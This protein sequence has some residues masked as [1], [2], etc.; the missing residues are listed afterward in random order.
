MDG[1]RF[2]DVARTLVAGLPR[3][4]V[5]RGLAGS[6][7]TALLIGRAVED[8]AACQRKGERCGGGFGGFS[9][10][11]PPTCA[12]AASAAAP[13][14]SATSSTGRASNGRAR[15]SNLTSPRH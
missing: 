11:V 4:R 8:V 13:G 2:D 10:A 12:A 6:V 14:R 9:A 5:L 7:L 3:R 1:N 15:A